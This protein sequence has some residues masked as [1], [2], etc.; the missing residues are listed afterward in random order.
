[1]VAWRNPAMGRFSVEVELANNGDLMRAAAGD[2]A[3]NLIRRARIRGVVDSGATRLVLPE[4]IV[5]QLGLATTESA[6]VRY[7]DNRTAFREMASG[8]ALTYAGRS[9][10]FTAVVEP[11]RDTALIGAI[12]MEDLDLIVDCTRQSLVPRDPER[13]VSEIE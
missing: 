4:H 3:E 7:A 5:K 12:V 10:V 1:M 13:I 8:V 6:T 2:I 9:G 11:Q